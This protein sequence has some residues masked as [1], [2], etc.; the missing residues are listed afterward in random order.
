[1][2]G[3]LSHRI[4]PDWNEMLLAARADLQVSTTDADLKAGAKR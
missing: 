1:M 4:E 3:V 2:S